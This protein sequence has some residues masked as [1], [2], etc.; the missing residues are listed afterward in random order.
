M[1]LVM[2]IRCKTMP[3]ELRRSRPGSSMGCQFE[4]FKRR[5]DSAVTGRTAGEGAGGRQQPGEPGRGR[6]QCRPRRHHR[7][8][9]SAQVDI[10]PLLCT[11]MHASWSELSLPTNLHHSTLFPPEARCVCRQAACKGYKI[12]IL[13]GLAIFK[14]DPI[15]R[16]HGA[17]YL[18]RTYCCL[19]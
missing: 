10:R 16:G 12:L 7:P 6:Q 3:L 17:Q 5:D 18:Y 11:Q 8:R 13:D 19:L 1:L 15:N 2:G 14:Q 9:R 4:R